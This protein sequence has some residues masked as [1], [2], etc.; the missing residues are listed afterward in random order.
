MNQLRIK[1][2]VSAIKAKLAEHGYFTVKETGVAIGRDPD[3]VSQTINYLRENADVRLAIA[4]LVGVPVGELFDES[5]ECMPAK[6]R[7]RV[8]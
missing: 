2:S 7:G 6:F 5:I 3:I 8:A 1:R 4:G